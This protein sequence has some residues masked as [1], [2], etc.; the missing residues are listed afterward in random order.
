[1]VVA[2]RP[3]RSQSSGSSRHIREEHIHQFQAAIP[4]QSFNLNPDGSLDYGL[5]IAPMRASTLS[6]GVGFANAILGP[7]HNYEPPTYTFADGEAVEREEIEAIRAIAEDCTTR[8][9]GRTAMSRSSTTPASCTAAAPLW[10]R[11]A[12]RSSVW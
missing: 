11:N 12:S 3:G 6:G 1:M 7:S 9:T 2:R 4:N 8:S 10:T 5:T